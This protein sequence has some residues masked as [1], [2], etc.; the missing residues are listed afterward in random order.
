M[1]W[2]P[3]HAVSF[4]AALATIVIALAPASVE[5]AVCACYSTVNSTASCQVLEAESSADCTGKCIAKGG[6]R[7]V[8]ETDPNRAAALKES[9]EPASVAPYSAP[10]KPY[11]TPQLSVDIPGV[12]FSSIVEKDEV[13]FVPFL[14]DYIGGLYNFLLGFAVTVA[15]IMLMVGGFQYVLFSGTGQIGAAKERIKNAIVG[16]V[17]LFAVFVLLYTVNPQLTLLQPLEIKYIDPVQFVAESGDTGGALTKD[18]LSKIGVT[19]NGKQ[20]VTALVNSL[21]NKVT[22]RFGAK[23]GTP[24]YAAETK[25]CE[26]GKACKNSCPPNTICLDCSGFVGLVAECAGLGSK[27]E[28]GG[29]AGIF[30]AAPKIEGC[31]KD[32]VSVGGGSQTLTPGDLLGFKAG[33]YEKSKNF[34]HVWIY[35][36]NGQ[37]ASSSGASGGRSAGKAVQI[38][39][40]STI[41]ENYPLRFVNR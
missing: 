5:A 23:G 11:L 40:L 25:T 13:L 32:T 16:L 2:K 28:G 34:G 37:V 12:K 20:D 9:C 18:Q 3:R 33:D 8:F 36:G 27:N 31:G 38:Q 15:I 22:Y 35:I 39:S 14:A 29:T 30:G 24:P 6:T 10:P 7:R 41:C 1:S 26:D 19:C 17:L 21:Q 4:L